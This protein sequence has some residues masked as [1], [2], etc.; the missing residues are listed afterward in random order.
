MR[1]IINADDFG[2][3]ADCVATTIAAI[4]A[5]AVTSATIMA[6][7][8]GSADALGFARAEPGVSFGVHLTFA[9]AALESPLSPP[10]AVSTLLGAGGRFAEPKV[11]RW[12]ALRGRIDQG[13]VIEEIRAQLAFVKDH[14]VAI[15]HVDSHHHLHKIEPFRT[16]LAETLPGFG[17]RRVR[18]AQ[19]VRV[20][21]RP[22]RPTYWNG[23]RVAARLGAL[24]AS[25]DWFVMLDDGRPGQWWASSTALLSG[26]GTLEFGCHPGRAEPWRRLELDAALA[27][28]RW[29]DS[30][31]VGR[32]DWR[33][34][35][36]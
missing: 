1:V 17:I 36:C 13:Q 15:S 31:G 7:M 35:E 18:N 9:G 2:L 4:R 3:D 29:C 28:A 32:I 26:D 27:F 8:P 5:G 11:I 14:G 33:D 34:V 25:T 19:N 6:N 16:A 22:W 12:R 21:L 30:R 10:A 20:G 24:F 23:A